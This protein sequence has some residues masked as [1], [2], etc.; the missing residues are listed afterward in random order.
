M[1]APLPH[2]HPSLFILF[3]LVQGLV[4]QAGLELVT[5]LPPPPKCWDYKA[6]ATMPGYYHMLLFLSK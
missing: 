5:L 6:H 2:T 3:C 1:V 4:V